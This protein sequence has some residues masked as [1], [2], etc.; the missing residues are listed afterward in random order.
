MA[1]K[2]GF[3]FSG[4]GAK[5]AQEIAMA[6]DLIVNRKIIPEVI[7]G[8]SS[9]SLVS[10]AVDS[11]LAG[12]LGWDRLKE[13]VFNLRNED[14]YQAP[15]NPYAWYQAVFKRGGWYDTSPLRKLLE[16]IVH[17]EIGIRY[18]GELKNRV[19]INVVDNATGDDIHF[20]SKNPEDKML[21]LV[22]AL[23][24]SCAIPTQFPP[25]KIG[26]RYYIDGGAGRDF[27]PMEA[28]LENGCD[29]VYIMIPGYA[30]KMDKPNHNS[31]ID[32]GLRAIG[33]ICYDLLMVQ[34]KYIPNVCKN[35]KFFLLRPRLFYNYSSLD[36][37]IG[38]E[39][40]ERVKQWITGLELKPYRLDVKC[41]PGFLKGIEASK[42]KMIV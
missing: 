17:Q 8:T 30:G 31:I 40:Y 33:F 27:A 18:L 5:I 4:A 14:V 32:N 23:M 6:E 39:Q 9:G 12:R 15:K 26:N 21:D 24:A 22:D 41:G 16:R 35:T 42:E 25:V 34:L 38:K 29:E 28:M 36:F 10:V 7:S 13:I 11:I 1:K 20:C 19:Y 3:V 37:T 2:I